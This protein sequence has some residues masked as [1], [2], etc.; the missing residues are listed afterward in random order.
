MVEAPRFFI[1][2]VCAHLPDYTVSWQPPHRP[3]SRAHFRSRG[4]ILSAR[5]AAGRLLIRESHQG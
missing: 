5:R 4:P 2:N 1:L 3:I